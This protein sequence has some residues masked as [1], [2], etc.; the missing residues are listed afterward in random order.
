M[1]KRK[2]FVPLFVLIFSLSGCW[3]EEKYETRTY[4]VMGTVLN[5]TL[6]SKHSY[7]ADSVYRIFSL[8]DSLMNPIKESSDLFK[9]N[10]GNGFVKVHPLT[11]ECI[12]KALEVS[13]V[14]DGAF[15]I[16]IGALVHLW[17]FDEYG[18]YVFP[19]VDS[20][21]KYRKLVD[22]RKVEL[23]DGMV[24]LGKGQRITLAG[25]AKGFAI[26]KSYEYLKGKGV[27]SGIIDAGGD[28]YL[29]G[30]KGGAKWRVGVRDPHSQGINKILVL[31]DIS[32]CTSGDYERYVEQNGKRYSHIFSP[33]TGYPVSNGVRSVTVVYK[34]ATLCDAFATAIF[35]LGPQGAHLIKEKGFDIE[36]Y[37]ITD[38]T[39]YYSDG[40]AKYLAY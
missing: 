19:P 27:N 40:F 26:Q 15:D 22:F 13:R 4:L 3:R 35:V 6:P 23:K 32:C 30:K 10:A 1:K 16:T 38:D 29:I 18:K 25:I 33:F 12:E 8:V 24:K 39:T 20:I 37:I 7:L 14:T 11:Y 36:Y 34:D 2:L 21:E 31:E 5:V 28:L 17:H 9:V